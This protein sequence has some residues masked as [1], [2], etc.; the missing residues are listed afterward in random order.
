MTMLF[1]FLTLKKKAMSKDNQN[2]EY[3]RIGTRYYR[4]LVKPQINGESQI[5]A[6]WNK[7]TIIMDYGKQFLSEIPKLSGFTCIPNHLD[8]QQEIQGF[9]NVYSP[10]KYEPQEGL[11]TNSLEF[12]KHIFGSQLDLGLDYLKLLYERPTQI[13]PILCLVSKERATGKSTF[14]K[15]LKTIFGLNMTY[16][17]GDN[18]SSQFNADWVKQLVIAIDEVF[19]DRKE[20]TERLK[21]LSTTDKD[22]IEAKGK[23]REE[24]EFFGKFILCSNNED[25][26][27]QIDSDEIRFWVRK[28]KPFQSEDTEFLEKLKDEIPAFLYYLVNRNYSTQKTLEC[29]LNQRI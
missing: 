6:K 19:F 13:L 2:S 23:D 11:T 18:F 24:I 27:I 9:Y 20:I 4:K 22:K 14:I 16:I 21:Y 25:S 7:E 12:M 28:I 1:M 15:W 17:K 8:F 3:I 29:G 10:L 26:F 5:M